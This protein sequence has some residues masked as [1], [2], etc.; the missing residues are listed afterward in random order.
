LSAKSA[1][2]LTLVCILN[3]DFLIQCLFLTST[4]LLVLQT[5]MFLKIDADYVHISRR[6]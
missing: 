6:C 5:P 4:A 1:K 3:V 2:L